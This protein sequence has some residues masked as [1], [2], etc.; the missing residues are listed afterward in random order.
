MGEV[1]GEL[2]I[3]MRRFNSLEVARPFLYKFLGIFITY[4][5]FIVGL[6]YFL[7]SLQAG[8]LATLLVIFLGSFGAF[9]IYQNSPLLRVPL[10]VNLNHPFMGD[11]EL[12]T[13]MVMVR[14]SDGTWGDVG[15]G[16]VRLTVD[17]LLGGT[18]LI[19]D[20]DTYG[21]I[22]H[23]SALHETHPTLKRYV[24]LINQAIA[25]RDAANGD[26]D[27]IETAREREQIES[28]LLERSWLE[29]QESIEIEPEGLLHKLRRE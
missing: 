1:R 25:L 3:E 4:E 24:M 23:F 10:A 15:E 28:G 8:L 16:R 18:L 7:F 13:A 14:F 17:E 27:L 2:S 20:D 12:G 21:V 26:E 6:L 11:L 9:S 22:G 29:G 19:R 5:L